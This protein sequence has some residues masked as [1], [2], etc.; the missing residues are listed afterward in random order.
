VATGK[1]R[2]E[3]IPAALLFCVVEIGNGY[4]PW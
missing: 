1:R 4:S 3:M 2:R